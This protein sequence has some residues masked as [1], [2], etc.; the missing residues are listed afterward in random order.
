MNTCENCY[1]WHPENPGDESASCIVDPPKII[2]IMGIKDGK[3]HTVMQ[4]MY[5][6]TMRD[7]YCRHHDARVRPVIKIA[8]HMPGNN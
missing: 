5:P 6:T 7:V 2:P 1:F 3:P 8:Q 4:N